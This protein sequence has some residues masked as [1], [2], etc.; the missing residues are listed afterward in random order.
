MYDFEIP[1]ESV[2]MALFAYHIGKHK[3]NE[4]AMIAAIRMAIGVW[5]DATMYGPHSSGHGPSRPQ[6][7]LPLPQVN[8]NDR[9][10]G[11]LE[12]DDE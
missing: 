4:E 2:K 7:V 10:G 5:P 11:C 9:W 8:P 3:T 1:E 12:N 6:L